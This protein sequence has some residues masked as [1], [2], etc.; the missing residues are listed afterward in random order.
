MIFANY[1][2]IFSC[3]ASLTTW[4]SAWDE[5]SLLSDVPVSHAHAGR[6]HLSVAQYSEKCILV[7]LLLMS[8]ACCEPGV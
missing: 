7:L 4:E 1:T 8:V 6:V 5:S 2:P 3:V